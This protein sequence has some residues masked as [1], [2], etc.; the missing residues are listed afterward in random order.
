MHF[1]D[2]LMRLRSQALAGIAAISTL[3][4]IFTKGGAANIQG[5]WIIATAIFI[6]LALFWIAIWCLDFLY[7]NR[8]LIG[9]VAAIVGLEEKSKKAFVNFDGIDM[10]TRIVEA[11]EKRSSYASFLGVLMFYSIVLATIFSGALFCWHMQNVLVV[12]P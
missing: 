7:Y 11:F 8:L 9:A 6:G 5:D 4:G 1:N 2:L 3:V 12:R 10:S